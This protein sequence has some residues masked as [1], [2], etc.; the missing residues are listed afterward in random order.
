MFGAEG[1]V[2]IDYIDP[3]TEKV[4]ERIEGKNHVF[5]E[6]LFGANWWTQL[7]QQ[8]P[9][10]ITDG[11]QPI[12]V[13]WPLMKGNIIGWGNPNK[14]SSGDY[15]GNYDSSN[16]FLAKRTNS[17]MASKFVY[18]FTPT[19]ALGNIGQIGLTSQ[20]GGNFTD[21]FK[22]VQ[23]QINSNNIIAQCIQDGFGWTCTTS[24]NRV[25][26]RKFGGF[27]E[28]MDNYNSIISEIDITDKIGNITSMLNRQVTRDPDTG[29]FYVIK[30][31]SGQSPG[32]G[33][34]EFSDESFDTVLRTWSAATYDI[35][36]WSWNNRPVMSF[37]N[38]AL[39]Y[40]NGQSHPLY[41]MVLPSGG[42][43]LTASNAG[44]AL[45]PSS[46]EK[47]YPNGFSTYSLDAGDGYV[48]R[49]PNTTYVILQQIQYYKE[50]YFPTIWDLATERP[51]NILPL[52]YQ[53]YDTRQFYNLHPFMGNMKAFVANAFANGAIQTNGNAGKGPHAAAIYKV[54]N[55]APPRPSGYGM[56]ITYELEVVY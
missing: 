38:G 37:Y 45:P 1:R 31:L 27:Y 15:R 19:Q 52:A 40:N 10:Y 54:P 51:V 46:Y 13:N 22:P 29:R 5:K 41:K 6:I 49:I 2:K 18:Q 17:G 55:D 28:G 34:Y 56:T 53:G 47:P 8:I 11:T 36:N 30:H 42:G 26:V 21:Y 16:S 48:V 20:F 39:Y 35:V 12:D 4:K 33:I 9:L 14:G 32:F 23:S 7:M 50:Q 24:N 43:T 25:I 44:V 3:L